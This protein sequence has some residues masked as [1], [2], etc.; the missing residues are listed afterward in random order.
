MSTTALSSSAWDD[1]SST[2]GRAVR[3]VLAVLALA[4][5]LFLGAWLLGY[6]RFTTDPRVLEARELQAEAQKLFAANGGPTTMQEAEAA[7]AAMQAVREKVEALPEPLRREVG[8]GSGFRATMQ[9]RINAYFALPPD[10]RQA[11]LDRQIAQEDL[12]R[13]AF[14]KANPNGWGGPPSGG[15]QGGGGQA[16]GGQQGGAGGGGQGGGGPPR[17]GSQDDQNRWRKGMID[18]T[19]PQQRTQYA[20]YRRAM[21]ARREQLGK[22]SPWGR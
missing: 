13:K 10:K 18:S 12:I 9:A 17:G 7:V 16:G 2:S 6:I 14:E 22:P 5:L 19:S 4:L 20:E 3:W 15:G 21:D 8:R 11:E 1:E